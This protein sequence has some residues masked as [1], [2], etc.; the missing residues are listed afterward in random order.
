[1]I[2][3]SDSPSKI[4]IQLVPKTA[5]YTNVRSNVS[6]E[7]WDDIRKAVYKKYNYKCMICGGKG[8]N[9]PVEAHELFEYNDKI[10]VQKLVDIVALCPTCHSVYHIG[11][12]TIRGSQ[13]LAIQHLAK[14]NNWELDK[15]VEYINQ[16]FLTWK[17]R[18]DHKW[19]LDLK[20]L[21]TEFG[22]KDGKKMIEDKEYKETSGWG[23]E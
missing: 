18:S 9:H 16:A 20:Y 15:T 22:I 12:T 1:M 13:N 14:I 19:R 23:N 11:L 8:E 17:E 3:K 7:D 5:F 4:D 21:E 6:K 10:H 2:R